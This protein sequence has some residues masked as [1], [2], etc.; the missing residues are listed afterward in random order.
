[1]DK[2]IFK[3][4]SIFPIREKQQLFATLDETEWNFEPFKSVIIN[5]A[6]EKI[7]MNYIGCGNA[8]GK[9]LIILTLNDTKYKSVED[10]CKLNGSDMSLE[11]I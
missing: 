2:T 5:I 1:M 11:R 9:P 10:I 6:G 8:E 3:I 7:N 4:K